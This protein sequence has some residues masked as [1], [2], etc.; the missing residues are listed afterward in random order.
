MTALKHGTLN[1]TCCLL[2]F[3]VTRPKPC[4][5]CELE[6]QCKA[7]GAACYIWFHFALEISQ[8][9]SEMI[10]KKVVLTHFACTLC[11]KDRKREEAWNKDFRKSVVHIY[12]HT[13]KRMQIK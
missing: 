13:Y 11:T 10:L 4:E 12:I 5:A 9:M 3:S 7:G 2:T 8:H 1:Q 6:L